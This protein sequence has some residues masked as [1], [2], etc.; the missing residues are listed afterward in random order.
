MSE[1]QTNLQAE[2]LAMARAM[3]KVDKGPDPAWPALTA[4]AFFA[5]CALGFAFG[6]ILAPPATVTHM[7]EGR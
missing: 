4:A 6:A 3:L 2:R 5:V 1:H 7:E